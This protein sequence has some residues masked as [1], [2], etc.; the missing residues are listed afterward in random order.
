M[1]SH[2]IGSGALTHINQEAAPPPIAK[3]GVSG[4]DGRDRP[5]ESAG[6]RIRRSAGPAAKG[7]DPS[8]LQPLSWPVAFA[9]RSLHHDPKQAI[10]LGGQVAGATQEETDDTGSI[11]IAGSGFGRP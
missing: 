11:R 1:A 7:C 6:C 2:K 9:R 8:G 10:G 3:Q 5:F 4:V